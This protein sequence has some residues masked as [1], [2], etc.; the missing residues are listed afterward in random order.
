MRIAYIIPSLTKHG[1]IIVLN[2]IINNI[3]GKV[4][5]I[6]VY[7]F[8]KSNEIELNVNVNF[9]RMTEDI[10]FNDYDII[11]S[12]INKLVILFPNFISF[13]WD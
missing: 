6:D 7:A 4:D 9:I 1:P 3:S 5:H 10:E 12:H 2:N 13:N 8:D 11:H